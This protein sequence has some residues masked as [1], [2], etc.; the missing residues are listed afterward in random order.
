MAIYPTAD[1]TVKG[2][3]AGAYTGGPPKGA[4]HTTEGVSGTGAIGAFKWSGSWPHFLVGETGYVWQFINTS[5]SARA[6]QHPAGTVET[7]RDHAI[8]IEIVGFAGQ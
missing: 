6:L 7:N 3:D 8:Q 4:L 1:L 5:L 2:T